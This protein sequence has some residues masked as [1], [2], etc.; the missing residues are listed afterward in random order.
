MVTTKDRNETLLSLIRSRFVHA[1]IVKRHANKPDK[2]LPPSIRPTKSIS[3]RALKDYWK[4]LRAHTNANATTEALIA[5][6]ATLD[7]LDSF[8][9]NIENCIGTLKMP[10]GVIGPLRINGLFACDDYYI[11]LATTE[12]TLVASYNRGAKLISE[13]GGCAT[14][15]LDTGLARG[16]AFAFKT[17]LET[18]VFASWITENFKELK[19]VAESTTKHGKLTEI[20]TQ[21]EGNHIYLICEYQTGDASGQNMTTIATEKLCHYLNDHAPVKPEYWFLEANF[22]SDKKASALSFQTVRG[23]KA[24]AEVFLPAKLVEKYLHTTPE[25]MYRYWVMAAMGSS[26][27][28]TFGV[29]G[30]YSN[31]LTAIYLATGQDAACAA[32]SSVGITR[33]EVR[34]NGDLYASVTLPNLVVGTVGGGTKLPVQRAALSILNLKGDNDVFTL[35]EICAATCLAGELSLIGAICA[36]QFAAAHNKLARGSK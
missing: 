12:A 23:K 18:G 1:D 5:D 10:M 9:N 34:D 21:I 15:L 13:A 27:S 36:N 7:V 14:A 2:P 4:I 35:A 24:S 8:E 16:P 20:R 26:M 30:H 19:A 25:T 31:A 33:L 22:S 3:L 17:L 6:P 28:G 29:Q 32:E 11:P